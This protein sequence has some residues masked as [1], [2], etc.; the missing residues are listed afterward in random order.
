MALLFAK[1]Q[2]DF[3]RRRLSGFFPYW[4]ID[5]HAGLEYLSLSKNVTFNKFL[6]NVFLIQKMRC[7]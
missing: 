2:T 6:N 4:L 3:R 5:G 7:K 1:K